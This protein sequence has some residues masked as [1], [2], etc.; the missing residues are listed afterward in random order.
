VNKV[1]SLTAAIGLIA[2][3]SALL[4]NNLFPALKALSNPLQWWPLLL[5][6]LGTEILIKF[7][8][9]RESK[10]SVDSIM[11]ILLL[12]IW[13]ARIYDTLRISLRL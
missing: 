1:G 8:R 11:V 10:I 2:L 6:G 4:L 3:G 5:I 9:C 13:L 7:G 12:V